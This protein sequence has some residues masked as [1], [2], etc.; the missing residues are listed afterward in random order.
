MNY[1]AAYA[2]PQPQERARDFSQALH[3]LGGLNLYSLKVVRRVRNQIFVRA[4]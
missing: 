1:F 3:P 2:V 4:K